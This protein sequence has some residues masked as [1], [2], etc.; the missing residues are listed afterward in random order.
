MFVEV[1]EIVFGREEVE[2]KVNG[3]VGQ[4][5]EVVILFE[6]VLLGFA[7][8]SGRFDNCPHRHRLDIDHDDHNHHHLRP[9]RVK[10]EAFSDAV[11]ANLSEIRSTIRSNEALE[12][13]LQRSIDMIGTESFE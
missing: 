7:H 3:G 6:Q 4:V 11:V 9:R 13:T 2:V 1:M 8:V 5:L 12:L 10:H